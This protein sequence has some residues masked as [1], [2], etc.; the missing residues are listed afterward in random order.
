MTAAYTD[1]FSTPSCFVMDRERMHLGGNMKG[2]DPKCYSPAVWRY[3]LQRFTPFS[4]LDVGCG[5]GD[6]LRWF[7]D[8]G[9]RTIGLEGL[10]ANAAQCPEPVIVHDLTR[11]S[12]KLPPV[13][14]VWCCEVVE[15]VEERYLPNLLDALGAG[16]VLAM[17]HA[18]PGQGGFHHVNEKPQAYWRDHLAAR[19]F[20]F[21]P[22]VTEAARCLADEGHYFRRSGLVFERP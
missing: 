21:L 2:G 18:L 4:V 7:R 9:M 19:G 10:E 16:R 1:N 20:A 17:T 12:A 11:G 5:T 3:L 14:L 22:D 6:A 13:D 15:H 8:H